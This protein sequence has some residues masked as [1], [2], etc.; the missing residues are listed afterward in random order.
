MFKP[1]KLAVC[2]SRAIFACA[3]FSTTAAYAIDPGALPDVANATIQYGS[4]SFNESGKTLDINASESTGING[5]TLINWG[6]TGFNVGKDSSV[7][8]QTQT[9][10]SIIVNHDMSGSLSTINGNINSHQ[11]NIVIVNPNGIEHTG[12]GTA[13]LTLLAG[14]PGSENFGLENGENRIS[15]IF[16]E[17][18]DAL[19]TS[20]IENMGSLDNGT[21]AIETSREAQIHSNVYSLSLHGGDQGDYYSLF[22]NHS[23]LKSKYL[24]FTALPY[25][26]RYIPEYVSTPVIRLTDSIIVGDSESDLSDLQFSRGGGWNDY[27]IYDDFGLEIN[28]SSINNATSN[29]YSSSFIYMKDSDYSGNASWASQSLNLTDSDFFGFT[30]LTSRNHGLA[31]WQEMV[32]QNVNFTGRNPSDSVMFYYQSPTPEKDYFL[33]ENNTFNKLDHVNF[34]LQEYGYAPTLALE[35]EYG[36]YGGTTAAMPAIMVVTAVITVVTVGTTVAMA[37]ITAATVAK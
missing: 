10:D 27:G 6:G 12:G 2:V 9:R 11:G 17:S 30:S 33:I 13:S 36:S 37:V 26:D 20:N 3:T 8:F 35:N 29:I 1:T 24:S 25:E 7:N 32:I 19:I 15:V 23:K 21:L 18:A 16:E 4:A 5:N 28:R 14:R 22:L 34:S 31:D